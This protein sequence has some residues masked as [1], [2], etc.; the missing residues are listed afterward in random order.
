MRIDAHQ[1]FWRYAENAADYP[2]IGADMDI[3]RADYGP[4]DL[5][6]L[7]AEIGFDGSVAVQA[8]ASER[9]NDALLALAAEHD[10]VL[11]VVGWFD[12]CDPAVEEHIARYADHPRFRGVR[13]QIHDYEDVDFAASEAHRRG[14]G[15]LEKYGLTY[16]LLLRPRNL[17]SATALVDSLPETRFVVDHIAKPRIADGWD[18]EWAEKIAAIAERP[19]VWCKLSGMVTEADPQ[20]W[21]EAPYDRYMDHVLALFG[22]TRLMIGSDWPV[23]LCAGDYRSVMAIVMGW[24]A[25]LSTDEQDAIFGGTCQNFYSIGQT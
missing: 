17:P 16:D 9:E 24:A 13:M 12:L 23:S 11:G 14:V 7:L 18:S 10:A 21:Q 19:N 1:H 4:E 5:R 25:K 15:L 20:R 2:W 6:P 3:L 22:P 8:R